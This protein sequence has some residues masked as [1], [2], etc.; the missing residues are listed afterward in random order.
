MS[1]GPPTILIVDDTP[2]ARK[3]LESLLKTEGYRLVFATSGPEALA[4][5]AD[6]LPDLILLD[7][8]LPEM[9]GYEVCRR[10]RAM[11]EI[12]EVAIIMVTSLD[13]RA[14]RL[15]G[16][17][18]GADDFLSKPFDWAELRSRVRTIT[19]LNRCRRLSDERQRYELLIRLSPDGIIMVDA[20]GVIVLA[21]EAAG[22]LL[23]R[24]G[25]GGLRGARLRELLDAADT[26]AFHDTFSRVLS[27]DTPVARLEASLAPLPGLPPAPVEISL[28]R[29]FWEDAPAVQCLI[30]DIPRRR[31]GG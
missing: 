2:S 15:R 13:D 29:L 11:P 28:G 10:L 14:S 3:T 7:V 30:R 19:R 8:M 27:G 23:G 25:G 9:D 24:G 5:A 12:A 21:N 31:E 6:L 16:L 1:P 22:S 26:G 18:A 17:D 20:A 4:C